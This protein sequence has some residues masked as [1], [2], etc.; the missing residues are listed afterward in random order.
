VFLPKRKLTLVGQLEAMAEQ[1]TIKT[2]AED[3][4]PRE[5]LLSKGRKALSNAEL[6][7]ILI[8]SGTRQKSAVQLS[9]E[10]L[11]CAQ[12]NLQELSRLTIDDLC[13]HKGIGAAKAITILASMELGRRR[14]AMQG[15]KKTKLSTSE[16]T[17]EYLKPIFEDLQVEE[18]HV[19]LLNRANEVIRPV[20]ISQGGVSGTTVDARL[21]FKA[22]IDVL[23]SSLILVHNHPSGQ[24]TPSPQDIQLTR[25]LSQ[26]GRMIDLPILDHLIFTDNGYFSFADKGML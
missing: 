1:L 14:R 26:F 15:K 24:L 18:F 21:I 5:K 10:L 7:A 17:Y 9:K 2:W 11:E 13:K 4:R 8:G 12:N 6:L 3:D 25:Q 23:A 16:V 19:L 20:K 22:A